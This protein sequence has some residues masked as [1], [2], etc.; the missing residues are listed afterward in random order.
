RLMQELG[1]PPA[2]WVLF[3]FW[4]WREFGPVA[5]RKKY[6]PPVAFVFSAKRLAE[7]FDWFDEQR[8]RWTGARTAMVPEHRRLAE[9]WRDMW[10]QLQLAQPGDREAVRAVV[11]TWFPGDV[12]ER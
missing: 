7:K 6:A 5:K 2:A 8:D 10:R 4:V 11:E 1:V 3:S 9:D 12:W